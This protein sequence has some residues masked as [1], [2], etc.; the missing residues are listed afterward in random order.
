MTP[1]RFLA[2]APLC[3]L[4]SLAG[5]V[6][7]TGVYTPVNLQPVNFWWHFNPSKTATWDY[8]SPIPDGQ[9]PVTILQREGPLPAAPAANP[10]PVTATPAPQ[11]YPARPPGYPAWP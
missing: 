8:F 1:F 10:Y 3:L 11:P 4:L 7:K 5:C 2:W 6:E 9:Q